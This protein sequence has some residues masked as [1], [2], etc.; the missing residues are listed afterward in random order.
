MKR[1][2][3]APPS[4]RTKI[5]R[6]KSN[7]KNRNS[8][9]SKEKPLTN[10]P[11]LIENNVQ[12]SSFGLFERLS[13]NHTALSKSRRRPRDT[14]NNNSNKIKTKRSN[15][16]GRRNLRGVLRFS[17]RWKST[18][19]DI[20]RSRVTKNRS[21]RASETLGEAF[22]LESTG[23]PLEIEFS[24]RMK[25]TCCSKFVPEEGFTDLDIFELGLDSLLSEYEAGMISAK[26]FAS[27]IMTT[28]SWRDLPSNIKWDIKCPLVRELA[29]PIGE[30]GYSF[31]IEA[32][33]KAINCD[34]ILNEGEEEGLYTA[35]ATGN[36]TFLPD[37][38]I[39][40]ENYSCVHD[41]YDDL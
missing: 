30:S 33:G 27:E 17:D 37:G 16:I 40:V 4:L 19:K 38:E 3:S 39:Q 18:P 15:S 8:K 1:S 5:S 14:S 20:G 10:T 24:S 23:P 13:E 31:M 2:T 11:S 22:D 28:L 41:V 12:S 29:M 21:N 7:E 32:N 9:Q 26:D 6:P 34:E 25:I 36:V 35:S